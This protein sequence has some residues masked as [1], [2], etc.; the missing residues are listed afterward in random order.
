MTVLVT[1]AGGFVGGHVVRRFLEHGY[2]VRAFVRPSSRTEHLEPLGVPLVYGDLR[3]PSSLHSALRGCRVLVHVAADYRLWAADPSELYRSNVEG[4]RAILHAALQ[5][6]VERVVYTST[7]GTLGIPPDGAPGTE[8][9]PVSLDDMVGHYKR[10]KFLAE[11]EVRRFSSE[12]HLPIVIVNPSTPVGEEDAKP[13]P[14]GKMIV[15]FLRG[16]MVGYIDTGLNLVDVR[17]VAEGHVLA[18]ERGKPGERYIL[19]NRNLTLHGIF[20]MLADITGRPAPKLKMPYWL[21][22]LAGWVDTFVEGRLLGREPGIP[23]EGVRM[24]RKRMFF[25]ASRA[26][27]ELGLPQSPVEDALARAVFWYRGHGYA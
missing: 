27:R 22:Y 25:D 13:S 10:S 2:S 5:E 18:L 4:T 6:G 9:T 11:Q 8:D 20:H 3:D 21:A 14:T 26:V 15:D 12:Y 7:V 24:A 23:L 17:D 1:G 19:G 16:R